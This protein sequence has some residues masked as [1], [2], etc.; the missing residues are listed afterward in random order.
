[1]L[2]KLFISSEFICVPPYSMMTHDP[3]GI[4]TVLSCSSMFCH[5]SQVKTLEPIVSTQLFPTC[6]IIIC[7]P[8]PRPSVYIYSIRKI[9]VIHRVIKKQP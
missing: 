6:S 5:G 3:S 1:M 7:D 4:Y 8:G 9:T 2:N